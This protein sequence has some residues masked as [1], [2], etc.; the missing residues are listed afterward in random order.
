MSAAPGRSQASSHRSPQGEGVQDCAAPGRSQASLHRSPQGEATP[1]NRARAIPASIAQGSGTTALF[2]LHGIG[3]GKQAWA[4]NMPALADA[5][6]HVVAWDMP[7]YGDS[8]MVEPCTTT[9]LAHALQ[10]LIQQVGA[11]RNLILGH[12]MGGM[13]AQEL[14]ALCPQQV[15]GLVLSGTSAAFGRADGTWQQSFLR[16]RFAPLDAGMDMASLARQLVPTMMAPH[17]DQQAR[18]GACAVMAAVPQASYRA[19]LQ[20]IVSFDRL[21]NLARI[22]VPTLCLAGEHDRNAPPH[23]MQRMADRIGQ[24]QGQYQCLAGV[25]HLA[26]MEQPQIFNCAVLDFLQAHFPIRG[27]I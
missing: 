13:V 3:G 14:V 21:D 24:G 1:G 4:A 9:E 18:T 6:Y 2:L 17:A 5:G 12:S 26:N 20:A 22:T 7:G 16:Q 23:V 10:R 11:E 19:A 15:D 27:G 25:G 8:A